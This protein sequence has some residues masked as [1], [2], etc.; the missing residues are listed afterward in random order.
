MS[1]D[2][3]KKA[4]LLAT[5]CNNYAHGIPQKDS[6]INLAENL[7]H[8][9]FSKQLHEY[10]AQFGYIEFFGHEVY[11]IIKED[12]SAIP[13]GSIVECALYERKKYNLPEHLVPIFF[14]DDGG[15]AYIDFS[16]INYAGEPM[17]VSA[18]YNG[19]KYVI[20]EKLSEDFGDFLLTMVNEQ[21]M[22]Q[23]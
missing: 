15:K 9:K 10:L 2:N 6:V 21:L 16:T 1:Y 19:M 4:I 17:I 20:T 13:E 5:K 8:V 22:S 3:F 18:Y 23:R 11:G 7:L 14:L 12:F